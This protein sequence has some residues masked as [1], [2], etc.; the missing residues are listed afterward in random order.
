M[1]EINIFTS[2][3][4]YKNLFNNYGLE[5]VFEDKDDVGEDVVKLENN[6]PLN[7]T[8]YKQP[9]PIKKKQETI[10]PENINKFSFKPY[11]I[12]YEKK[13]TKTIG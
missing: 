9:I 1:T 3:D 10:T 11:V 6:I 2:K 8:R 13:K 4:K 12:N 5:F 7:K